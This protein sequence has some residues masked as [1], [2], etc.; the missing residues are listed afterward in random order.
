MTLTRFT[1]G[2]LI[3]KF[4]AR[5]S[6]PSAISKIPQRDKDA[7]SVEPDARWATALPT[8]ETSDRFI[9]ITGLDNPVQP[10]C[11]LWTLENSRN[12]KPFHVMAREDPLPK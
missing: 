7:G 5:R 4:Q 8:T 3:R 12:S 2:A 9:T 1:L 11:K 6:N 10:K